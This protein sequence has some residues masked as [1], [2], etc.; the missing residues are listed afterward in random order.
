MPD[1]GIFE[2]FDHSGLGQRVDG[3]IVKNHGW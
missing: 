3:K 1:E 2:G